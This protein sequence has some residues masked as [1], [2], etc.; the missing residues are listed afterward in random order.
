M[1][2]ALVFACALLIARPPSASADTFA[3]DKAH[4]EV[5]FSWDHLGLSR[6]AGRFTEV[7]GTLTFDPAQPEA[8]SVAVEIKVASLIT[9]VPAL[10]ALLT[11]TKDYFDAAANPVIS[12][13]SRDVHSTGDKTADVTGDLT[14][15]GIAKPATLAVHWNYLGP[16]PLG[17]I[18]PTFK[19]L[20]VAGFSARTQILRSDWGVSR[21]IPLVSDEIR[22]S[23]E[24]ELQRTH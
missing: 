2:T 15:N 20:T 1:R 18:N 12:F 14:I 11:K 17:D 13:K 5:R 19:D 6:Q 23:I 16:H 8:A 4:T 24:A 9:G 7:S 21:T 3:F 22:I 10:D